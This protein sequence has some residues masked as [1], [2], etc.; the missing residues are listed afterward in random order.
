MC[1][2]V[3]FVGDGRLP[4]SFIVKCLVFDMWEL[5]HFELLQLPKIT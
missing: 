4:S 5:S 2:D 3:G 1:D